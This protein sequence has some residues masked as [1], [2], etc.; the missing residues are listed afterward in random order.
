M[1]QHN[2]ILIPRRIEGRKERYKHII[3]RQIQQYI[4]NG[5]K[6]KLILNQTTIDYLPDN[7][8]YVGG[9]LDLIQSMIQSIGNLEFVDGDLD[10]DFTQ[11]QSL[12]NL[13]R[14]NGFLGLD[15]TPIKSFGKLKIVEGNLWI[16]NTPL[17]KK[18]TEKEIRQMV[19]VNK[20]VF[21]L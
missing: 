3:Y 5:C 13:K 21:M 1:K 17:A 10:L 2:N 16:R 14:V 20:S 11:I 18:Y 7:L 19:E 8:I 6:G 4:K 12:G 15:H 9:D